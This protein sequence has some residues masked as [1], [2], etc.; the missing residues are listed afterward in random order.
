MSNCD[1]FDTSPP[2]IGGCDEFDTSPPDPDVH[3]QENPVAIYYAPEFIVRS[4]DSQRTHAPDVHMS[5]AD[6]TAARECAMKYAEIRITDRVSAIKEI[7]ATLGYSLRDARTIVD[8]L[9]EAQF[10]I[11]PQKLPNEG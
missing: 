4:E 6:L 1:E 5:H 9:Q 2:D 11:Q 7:R 3:N 10:N 8:A